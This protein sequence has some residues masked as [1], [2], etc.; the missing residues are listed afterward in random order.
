M[1]QFLLEFQSTVSLLIILQKDAFLSAV[2]NPLISEDV[3][4][5]VLFIVIINYNS[6]RNQVEKTR[7]GYYDITFIV[8]FQI[9]D[10]WGDSDS[11]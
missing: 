3:R 1:K 2:V 4:Y 7:K 10:I 8:V 11:C 6:I 5:S 9:R